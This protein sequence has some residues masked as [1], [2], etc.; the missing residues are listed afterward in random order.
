[1]VVTVLKDLF[2]KGKLIK[3]SDLTLGTELCRPNFQ[4]EDSVVFQ[5]GLQECGNSLQMTPDFLIYSTELT[6]SPTPSGNVPIIRT[7]AAK[8]LVQ[9]YYQRNANV[10]SNA[11]KPTWIPFSSTVSVEERLSFSLQLMN[12]DWSAPRTSTVFHL[13]DVFHIEASLDTAN[14]VPM[15]VFV[16]S[17]VATLYPDVSSDPHYDIIALNGCLMDGKQ[18]DSSSAF[19]SPRTQS[20]KL[21]FMVDAFRF[22]GTDASMI[23]VTC[24]LRAVA[25]IQTPDPVN[26][27]CSFSKSTNSWSP[28]EGTPNICRCCDTGNCMVSPQS[29]RIGPYIGGGRGKRQAGPYSEQEHGLATLG[30]LMIIE[31]N[32]IKT[33][34]ETQDSGSLEFW[35]L[36]TIG[37]LCIC[38]VLAI[39]VDVIRKQVFKKPIVPQ[40]K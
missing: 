36:I 39:C 20:N 17:C 5:N 13:G 15:M 32:S 1:M 31:P 3:V 27:A 25:V 35:V 22:T 30:P 38:F 24:N 29:R 23:Y 28:V 7:N 2:R 34:T 37:S 19:R 18:E 26:K 16:D 8:I 21:Q 40:I 12:D 14:H 33:L 9:C 6:Y 11:I 4:R 10:S